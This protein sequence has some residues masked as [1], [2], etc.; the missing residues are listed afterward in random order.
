MEIR[1][2]ILSTQKL[3]AK[4]SRNI[5]I[6]QPMKMGIFI[7]KSREIVDIN[8]SILSIAENIQIFVFF[9]SIA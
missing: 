8:S 2:I 7:S 9:K 4:E 1:L 6:L 3:G 5:S